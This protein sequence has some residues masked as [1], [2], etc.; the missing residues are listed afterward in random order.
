MILAIVFCVFALIALI[1]LAVFAVF[2]AREKNDAGAVMLWIFAA[3]I[4]ICA[5]LAV[6]RL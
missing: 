1:R 3:V 4:F 2:T 5:V 6:I